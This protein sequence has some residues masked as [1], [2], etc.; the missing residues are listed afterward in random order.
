MKRFLLT[1]LLALSLGI[2]AA[3]AESY[4]IEF[5]PGNNV[6]A[7]KSNTQPTTVMTTATSSN[8]KS[9]VISGS[10]YYKDTYGIR[11]GKSSGTGEITINVSDEL[12]AIVPT[13]I[14]IKAPQYNTDTGKLKVNVCGTETQLTPGDDEQIISLSGNTVALDKI[15]LAS[16]SKRVHLSYIIV[17]YSTDPVAVTPIFSDLTVNYGED[18]TPI[19][20]E[21]TDFFAKAGTVT[22]TM[23]LNEPV[24]EGEEVLMIDDSCILASCAGQAT[25]TA[26]WNDTDNYYAGTATFNVTVNALKPTLSYSAESCEVILEEEPYEFPVLTADNKGLKVVY[27]SSD[28][29]VAM[30]DEKTG[31]LELMG[32]GTTTITAKIEAVAGHNEGAEASYELTVKPAGALA[33]PVFTP[34]SGT[35]ELSEIVTIEASAGATI[36]YGV[37]T[38]KEEATE[39]YAEEFMLEDLGEVTYVAYAKKGDRESDIVTVTYNVVPAKAA[40]E[41]KT[42]AGEAMMGSLLDINAL[43]NNP[44]GLDYTL[45]TDNAEVARVALNDSKNI[46]LM[47]AGNVTVTATPVENE[48]YSATA[49]TYTLTVKEEA[50]EPEVASATLDFVENDYGMKPSNSAYNETDGN[51]SYTFTEGDIVFKTNKGDGIGTRLFKNTSGREFRVY[52]NSSITISAVEGLI[53]EIEFTVGFGKKFNCSPSLTNNKW[54][55]AKGKSSVTFTANGGQMNIAKI[56]ITYTKP[57][58]QTAH[59]HANLAFDGYREALVDNFTVAEPAIMSPDATAAVEYIV[60]DGEGNATE[61]VGVE[62]DDDGSIIIASYAKEEAEY[63]LVAYIDPYN[64]VNGKY[65]PAVVETPLYVREVIMPAELYLHGHFFNRYYDLTA[66]VK[67]EKKGRDFVATDILIGG[68]PEHAGDAYDYVFTTHKLDRAAAESSMMRA[69][70]AAGS[71]QWDVLTE[72]T[73]YH[74]EIDGALTA[75]AASDVTS[76]ADITPINAGKEG[77]YQITVNFDDPKTPTYKAVFT[78]ITTGIE[79]VTVDKNAEAVYYDLTGRRVANPSAGVFIRVQG[80]K[81]EKIMI[82]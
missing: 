37:G 80:G 61:E 29:N 23:A 5:L 9:F 17:E 57:G 68:N 55:D 26:S 50:G 3:W 7:M 33:S 51:T 43:L 67:M 45:S 38:T 21:P 46:W 70:A 49:T 58:T 42:A 6:T 24:V 78:D 4:K 82:K 81:A 39:V 11:L 53:T 56:K 47:G 63:T 28:E 79:G 73:V 19:V 44:E 71:H 27:S 65:Y 13:A 72:G 36:Y 59:C 64:E 1:L 2:G 10:V 75:T 20:T 74:N 18:V 15:T 12:S 16:T 48:N 14:R 8:A 31:E 54:T 62:T 30:I 77:L 76:A 22:Y 40:F 34:E 52:E 66:P 32:E 25:V 69:A 35:Y 60:L 41:F